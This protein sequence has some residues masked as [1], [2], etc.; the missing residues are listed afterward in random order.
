MDGNKWIGTRRGLVKHDG[1]TWTAYD[2]L[3]SDLPDMV[4][5]I[6]IDKQGNKWIGIFA[7]GLAV[8]KEGGD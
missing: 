6:A 4:T 7:E 8:F 2:T 1:T 5:P 3:N